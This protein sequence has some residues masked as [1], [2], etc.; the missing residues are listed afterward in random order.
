MK[1]AWCY[2]FPVGTL[3]IAED[4]AGIT[5]IFRADGIKPDGLTEAETPMIK[6]AAKQLKEYFEGRR[7]KFELPLSL[8]GTDFQCSVWRALQA[9]PYGETRSYRQIAE[10]AGSPKACRA[11][12]MANHCN[13]VMIVVPCHRVIGADGS[14]VGY[15]GGLEMKEFL[16]RLE[17][18][19]RKK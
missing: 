7:K 16:L 5:D 6:A 18:E 9:I 10:Q 17:K 11:V 3:V 14:M 1:N 15:G 4:G 8:S 19:N 2:D 12:G 13:P